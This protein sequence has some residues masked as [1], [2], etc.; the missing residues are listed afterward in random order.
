MDKHW[1]QVTKKV[2]FE[3]VGRR[4]V[5]PTPEGAYPYTT[6]WKTPDGH[7]VGKSEDYHPKGNNGVIASRYYVRA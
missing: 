2:F 7:E 4:N 1:K 6:L 3:S 5:H